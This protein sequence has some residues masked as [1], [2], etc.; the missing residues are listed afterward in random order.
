[1]F[2]KEFRLP[3]NVKFNKENQFFSNFFSIKVD[4]NKK[5]FN[6]FGIIVSKKIDSRAVIRNKIKREIRR[7][8]EENEKNVPAGKDMLIIVRPGIKDRQINEICES[9]SK[10]FK[11]IK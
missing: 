9:V 5:D 7:C 8:I 11:K 6:R 3:K 1:M 10:L 2:K 4:D